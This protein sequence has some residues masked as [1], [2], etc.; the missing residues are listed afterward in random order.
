M[1]VVLTRCIDVIFK[2]SPTILIKLFR[3]FEDNLNV[4]YV[5]IIFGLV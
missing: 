5:Q 1:T 2:T 4:S 3:K